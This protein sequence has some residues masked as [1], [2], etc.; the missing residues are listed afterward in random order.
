MNSSAEEFQHRPGHLVI[1][2]I[3]ISWMAF[4]IWKFYRRHKDNLKPIHI[5]Q[6]HFYIEFVLV[7]VSNMFLRTY[8]LEKIF[9]ENYCFVINFLSQYTKLSMMCSCFI[10]HHEKYEYLR[11]KSNYSSRLDRQA[12][13]DRIY[14]SKFLLVWVTIVGYYFDTDGRKCENI[15]NP[16]LNMATKNDILWNVIPYFMTIYCIYKVLKYAWD[17]KMTQ[18]K[19]LLQKNQ[20]AKID[21]ENI[22]TNGNSNQ[23]DKIQSVSSQVLPILVPGPSSLKKATNIVHPSSDENASELLTIEKIHHTEKVSSVMYPNNSLDSEEDEIAVLETEFI[24]TDQSPNNSEENQDQK[25]DFECEERNEKLRIVRR[26]AAA[27][28]FY[29][30]PKEEED[31]SIEPVELMNLHILKSVVQEHLQTFLIFLLLFPTIFLKAYIFLFYTFYDHSQNNNSILIYSRLS[32]V[33]SI[34]L[35]TIY[36][37]MIFVSEK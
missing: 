1:A 6:I 7:T 36:F 26:G 37:I 27:D 25:S 20:T 18:E 12:A 19:E 13:W 29:R 4:V 11:L 34:I 28:M 2:T 14:S 3:V 35:S 33:Y 9:S 21:D 5:L 30:E 24:D 15:E 16:E 17:E 23:D 8:G 22:P 10:L 31:I 32:G